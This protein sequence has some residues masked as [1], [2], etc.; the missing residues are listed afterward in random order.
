MTFDLP[1]LAKNIR[2]FWKFRDY[3]P[4]K[5]TFK[6]LLSWLSQFDK[7]DRAAA[8]KLIASV[9]Y[10]NEAEVRRI[11]SKQNDALLRHLNES[12]IPPKNVIYV[13]I[14]TAGSSSAVMLNLLRDAS[15]LE[16]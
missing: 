12:G 14:D 6:T 15:H 9:N 4:K 1:L 7:A 16:R 2:L 11:L 3:Q 8:L 10:L 13:S 5:I